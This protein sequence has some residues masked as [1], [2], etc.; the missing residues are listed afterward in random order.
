MT[1]APLSKI[2]TYQGKTCR[3]CGNTEKY[4]STRACVACVKARR[5]ICRQNHPLLKRR[6]HPS[7]SQT[8]G[9]DTAT[10]TTTQ[11]SSTLIATCKSKSSVGSMAHL[12]RHRPTISMAKGAASVVKPPG[13]KSLRPR[14]PR[15]ST[16]PGRNTATAMTTQ[17]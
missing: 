10:A 17:K 13:S 16:K 12:I 4:E 14:R 2:K 5:Q 11:K 6:R 9:K 1:A 8:P 3:N 15:L 7:L